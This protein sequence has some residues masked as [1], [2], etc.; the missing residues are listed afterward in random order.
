MS[1][2]TALLSLILCSSILCAQTATYK[3]VAVIININSSISDSIGQ[4]FVQQRNIPSKN[5]IYVNAPV[6]EEIDSLQFELLR[7]Q[8]EAYLVS[9]NLKDSVNYLVTTKG[10]PLKVHRAIDSQC[11]SVESELA[12]I[13]G[14]YAQYIGK[15]GKVVSPYYKK[16]DD[17]LR[18]RYGIYLVTRLDGYTYNDMKGIIDRTGAIEPEIPSGS[19]FVFDIDPNWNALLP[20]LNLNMSKIS[21]TLQ[22]R[23]YTSILD[24]TTSYLTHQSNVIGYSSWGSNDYHTSVHGIVNNTWA[25]GA[26]AETYV[27]TSGRTFSLPALYGQSL[28]A[29]LIAE[30]ITA[31]KGYV[32]E[33]YSS[34]MAD[35]S[36]LFDRYVSGYTIAESYYS[37]SPYL[38]WMDVVIGDPKFRL[39]DPRLPSDYVP[40]GAGDNNNSLPVEIASFSANSNTKGVTLQWTTATEVNNHGFEIQRA[41]LGNQTSEKNWLKIGFVKGSGNSNSAKSYLFVD[42]HRNDAAEQ[43]NVSGR[44]VYRLKQIDNDGKFVYSNVVEARIA[45]APT[46]CVLK[47]NYPNP[48]NP[49]TMISYQLPEGGNVILKVYDVIGKEVAT[50]VDG[51]QNAG[52]HYATFSAAALA[53][54]LYFYTI[55]TGTFT[56]TKRMMLMK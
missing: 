47:Q 41:A 6:T 12:L 55:K 14:S 11:S 29:D 21:H 9:S 34:A 27:S 32:Y 53:S 28:I 25:R 3:D 7:I 4:Y 33:P 42:A 1:R 16:T 43:G 52:E 8:I 17:F 26:I 44:V 49:T 24:S 40:Y 18:S 19:Q 20:S 45:N 31:A 15:G 5:I 23:G 38:S 46:A 39:T 30:G 50:L 22:S 48:F 56:E 10:V 2:T 36:V 37:S 51:E 35:V 13:L 54:G